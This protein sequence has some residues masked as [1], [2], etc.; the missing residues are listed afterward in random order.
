[1]KIKSILICTVI[2]VVVFLIYLANTDKKI[3][4]VSI[5]D[6]E[7]NDV[8]KY[9]FYVNKYLK[10]TKQLEYFINDFSNSNLR[11]TD[12]LNNLDKNI[13]INKDNKKISI[14]HALIK[15][16]L[17]TLY[18]DNN[19]LINHL[20]SSSSEYTFILCGF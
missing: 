14:Q 11:I 3:Y 7:N 20:F 6:Y 1:M 10:P 2:V 5:N 17:V 15:A 13:E 8:K 4:Y 16:D 12:V 9:D 18:L 19:D